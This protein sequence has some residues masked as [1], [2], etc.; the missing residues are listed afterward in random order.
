MSYWSRNRYP[1]P[2]N[3]TAMLV[4]VSDWHPTFTEIATVL[5]DLTD[6]ERRVAKDI[7]AYKDRKNG[8]TAK[9]VTLLKTFIARHKDRTAAI[10]VTF[11]NIY[12]ALQHALTH[13]ALKQPRMTFHFPHGGLSI[14]YRDAIPGQQSAV[15]VLQDR[16]YIG[17]IMP[18]GT[19][20]LRP[21][22]SAANRDFLLALDRD[23]F[24]TAADYGRK[25][26]ACCFCARTLTDEESLK[27]GYGPICGGR[28]NRMVF[29]VREFDK[30]YAEAE[31]ENAAELRANGVP[32]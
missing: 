18:D 17:K 28:Y 24:G 6:G 19:A 9:Q 10:R 31:A 5:N 29:K 14:V 32:T 30:A 15:T 20:V 27:N 23:F 12:A 2:R 11:H 13:G 7:I 21:E 3:P 22:L 4:P 26:G 16:R 25:T 8:M 1:Q